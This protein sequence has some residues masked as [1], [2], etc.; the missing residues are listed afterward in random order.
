MDNVKLI[1]D[2]ISCMTKVFS[3]IQD[4]HII[5]NCTVEIRNKTKNTFSFFSGKIQNKSSL[6]YI[7]WQ[8]AITKTPL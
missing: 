4:L 7:R 1:K 3:T 6:A 8:P 5:L 2:L